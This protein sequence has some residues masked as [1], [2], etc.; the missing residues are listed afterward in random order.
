M[1]I[2][3]KSLVL[4]LRPLWKAY[5]L[6]AFVE[7]KT[8][9]ERRSFMRQDGV[10]GVSYRSLNFFIFVFLPLLLVYVLAPIFIG[11]ALAPNNYKNLTMFGGVI[12]FIIMIIY[13]LTRRKVIVQEFK[14]PN[15]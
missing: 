8:A 10:R 9:P 5:Y 12:L 2:V 13:A 15:Y 1:N 3:D 7:D 11:V 4:Y 14:K 6:A